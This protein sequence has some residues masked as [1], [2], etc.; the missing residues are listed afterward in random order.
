MF[1]LIIMFFV[2]LVLLANITEEKI[3]LLE[4]NANNGS[5]EAMYKLG[6]IYENGIGVKVDFKQSMYWYKKTSSAYQC[7]S[8]EVSKNENQDSSFVSNFINQIG[9]TVDVEGDAYT[10]SI[11]D[12]NT[13][14]TKKLVESIYENNFFGLTPFHEN[15]LL[16]IS[17][18][19]K[20]YRRF[21]ELIHPNATLTPEQQQYNEY[22]N[23]E[24]EFQ[25]SFKKRLT[26]DLFGW[27]ESLVVA[28]TQKVWWQFYQKSAPFREMDIAPEIF[29]SVPSSTYMN[30][31]YGL[32]SIRYGF[33]HES[34]GQDGYRSRSW[35]RLHITGLWQWDNLFLS[36]KLW[37]RVPESLKSD[38]YYN[39]NGVGVNPNEKGD[40]NPNIENYLGYG[41]IHLH[42]LYGNNQ[43]STML[44]Y[45]FGA[46]GHQRGAA[47]FTW[48]Y[49][50]FNSTNMFWYTKIFNG[51]GESLIDYDRSI[52]KA[53]FGFSFSRG[54]F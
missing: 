14:E 26:Y 30:E 7:K 37:Y 18:S 24:V 22:S 21:S 47:E 28:Y 33:L 9:T 43:F 40:D 12:I 42:Y 10:L 19:N 41:D 17:I 6:Y 54:L 2:P 53:S 16:P 35:N 5:K 8:I 48:S 34:N 39:S 31:N 23:D 38:A 51:Y 52:T 13:V 29:L 11:L 4:K 15:Y 50:F 1:K 49:P 27:N 32:K 44:R 25:I 45:N 3:K 36:T 46:G 20:K